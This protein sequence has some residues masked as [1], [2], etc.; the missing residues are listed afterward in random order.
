M[1][2]MGVTSR[3]GDPPEPAQLCRG[4]AV[5]NTQQPQRLALLDR[6]GRGVL[7][8][9]EGFGGRE[10]QKDREMGWAKLAPLS[11]CNVQISSGEGTGR[12]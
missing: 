8:N 4:V 12:V 10:G 1:L 3:A 6:K 5:S 9:P 11:S 7:Q 2:E